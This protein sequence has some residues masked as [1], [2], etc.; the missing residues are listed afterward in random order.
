MFKRILSLALITVLTLSMAIVGVSA[1]DTEIAETGADVLKIE[2]PAEWANAESV[3]AHVWAWDGSGDWPAWQSKKEKCT[4][5]DDGTWS[6]DLSKTGNSIESGKTYCVIFS[7]N[8]G[9]QSYNLCFNTGNI[10]DTAY[11][12]GTTCE[13]PED[14]NKTAKIARWRSGTCGPE[15]KITSI[16]NVVGEYMPPEADKQKMYD[17]FV[18]NTLTN[19]V[20]YSGKTEDQL[21]KELK[22]KLGLKDD[23]S[24]APT[25]TPGNNNSTS[26]NNT[27]SRTNT[28][29]SASGNAATGQDMTLT[30]IMLGVMLASAGIIFFA[31][32]KN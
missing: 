21:K 1:A 7:S 19:A 10:G 11:L 5:N 32:K 17:D 24:N 26:N 13:N 4:K 3:F 8:S 6:Y 20:T 12:D 9:D 30:I 23:A 28:A 15:F 29:T 16:G 27:A 25:S 14:S 22:E 2:T 18:K 31:R